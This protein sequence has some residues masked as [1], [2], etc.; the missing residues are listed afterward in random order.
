MLDPGLAFEEVLSRRLSSLFAFALF[1]AGDREDVAGELLTRAVG[2]AFE[3]CLRGVEPVAALQVALVAEAVTTR[4]PSSSADRARPVRVTALDRVRLG[5]VS[6][7]RLRQAA[8]RIPPEAR[9]AIWLVV[10]ERR[11][12]ADAARLL[13]TDESTLSSLLAW[14]DPLIRFA[15]DDPASRGLQAGGLE[16]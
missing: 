3:A 8:A 9:A 13:G 5:S 4:G 16:H 10:V 1:L 12:Y 6:P 15:L 7:S 14:R 2:R 11:T